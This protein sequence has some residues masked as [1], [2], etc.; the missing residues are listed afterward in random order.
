VR[1]SITEVPQAAAR[2]VL[3]ALILVVV[4]DGVITVVSL[5]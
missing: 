4:I 2:A 1:S 3:E 5:L